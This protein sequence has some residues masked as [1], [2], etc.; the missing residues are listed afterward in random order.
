MEH[1]NKNVLF[2]ITA[3]GKLNIDNDDLKLFD[4]KGFMIDEDEYLLSDEIK[5]S[6]LIISKETPSQKGKNNTNQAKSYTYT[7]INCE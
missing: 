5:G 2:S 1:F 7:A 4:S 6:I 3:A